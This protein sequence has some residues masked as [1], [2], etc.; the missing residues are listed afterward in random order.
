M[1]TIYQRNG[2]KLRKHRKL[3]GLS[4]VDVAKELHLK[5][6]AI[7]SRWE[8][9]ITQPSLDNALRLSAL[10]KTLVNELFWDLFTEYR[11]ELF[12]QD[13]KHKGHDP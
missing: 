4:Q 10:Y 11:D 8:R 7:I 12:K 5:S 6:S 13:E 1:T 3:M 2:K 9:G